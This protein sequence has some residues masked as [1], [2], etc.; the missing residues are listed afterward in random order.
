MNKL[1][2]L[3]IIFD[4]GGVLID[5]NPEHLYRNIFKDDEQKMKYFLS[6]VCSSEWNAR[7]DKG[8]SFSKATEERIKKFPE[9][10]SYIRAYFSRWEETVK[11]EIPG[12]VKIL[13]D[14]RDAGYY[15][16]ALT[17]WSAETYPLVTD[18]FEFLN[19][20]DEVIVSGREKIAKP[21]PAIYKLLLE[22]INREAQQ[23]L[24]I[25]D[26]EKNVTAAKQ[27]GFQAI[28]YSSPINLHYELYGRLFFPL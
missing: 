28:H 10:E 17:N 13:S 6:E 25:D 8:Y 23:C 26:S 3:A 24:F 21:D 14:L 22:R 16:C 15:L 12:T 5:W 27:L 1:K 9:F 7:Q 19:W 11:G 18:R 2:Q 20:F 4:L